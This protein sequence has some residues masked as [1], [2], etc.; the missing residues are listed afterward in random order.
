M[1]WSNFIMG[2]PF[3]VIIIGAG[4]AG[5]SLAKFAPHGIEYS[6]FFALQNP[7]R[8]FPVRNILHKEIGKAFQ[9]HGFRMP[10]P[11]QDVNIRT[12]SSP[13]EM[14]LPTIPVPN[15]TVVDGGNL[16]ALATDLHSPTADPVE[17]RD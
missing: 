11:Q 5:G 13:L 7:M 9:T 16:S 2:E 1:A 6:A 8:F 10:L 14:S 12:M 15:G 3:H 4:Q 17:A